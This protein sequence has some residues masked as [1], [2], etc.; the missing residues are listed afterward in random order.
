MWGSFFILRDTHT[1][2]KIDKFILSMQLNDCFSFNSNQELRNSLPSKVLSTPN[3]QLHLGWVISSCLPP[4]LYIA[5]RVCWLQQVML[6]CCFQFEV[7]VKA[8]LVTPSQLS[9]MFNFLG[10]HSKGCSFFQLLINWQSDT[11]CLKCCIT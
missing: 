2:H 5:D 3:N 11:I 9:E 10:R 6:N 7:V 1:S 4:S 8:Y